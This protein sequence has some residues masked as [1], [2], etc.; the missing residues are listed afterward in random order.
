MGERT[1]TIDKSELEKAAR[2]NMDWLEREPG[3]RQSPD[4][5]DAK[6]ESVKL[7]LVPTGSSSGCGCSACVDACKTRPGWFLPGEVAKAAEVLGIT[8]AEFFERHCAIDWYEDHPDDVFVVAPA[9][10]HGSPGE[11]YPRNPRGTCAL[12]TDDGRCSIHDVKPFECRGYLHTD[13]REQVEERREHIVDQWRSKNAQEE[14]RRLFD[15][16]PYAEPT[17][18]WDFLL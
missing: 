3:S 17:S 10:K 15:G 1:V 12:L 6:T 9:L 14:V 16:E 7:P 8:E 2:K 11:M 13:S 5:V 4:P 18:P